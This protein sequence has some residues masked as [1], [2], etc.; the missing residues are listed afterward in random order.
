MEKIFD[1]ENLAHNINLCYMNQ[2]KQTIINKIM[3]HLFLCFRICL[4]KK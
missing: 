1:E 4:C 2:T 3:N